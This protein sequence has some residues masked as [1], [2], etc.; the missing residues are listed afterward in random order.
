M[1]RKRNQ[2]QQKQNQMLLQKSSAAVTLMELQP[3]QDIFCRF[4]WI[5]TWGPAFK[6]PE[7]DLSEWHGWQEAPCVRASKS[8][9]PKRMAAFALFLSS[10]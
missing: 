10:H 7:D 2:Q 9:T 4:K 5:N 8:I 3:Q 6:L 1:K